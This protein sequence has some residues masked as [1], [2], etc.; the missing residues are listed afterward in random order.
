MATVLSFHLAAE[1]SALASEMPSPAQQPQ[2]SGTTT[3]TSTITCINFASPMVGNLA[4]E[5]AFGHLEAQGLLRC[6]RVTN[7]FDIFTQLPDRGNWLYV[8]A[9]CCG[10]TLITYLGWS[11]LFFLLFQNNVYRHVGMDLHMY[12]HTQWS[13]PCCCCGGGVG[14]GDAKSKSTRDQ[15]PKLY[16]YKIKHSRGTPHSFA[17]R[18]ASDW[19]KHWK[20]GIQRLLMIPFVMNFNTNHSLQEHLCRLS[21][22]A[23][24]LEGVYLQDLYAQKEKLA[25]PS[26]P[27]SVEVASSGMLM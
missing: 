7:H 5:H 25:R 4:F 27:L 19:K 3:A 10:A 17:W 13:W 24:E 16:S 9:C 14:V 2:A 26:S 21:G 12:K 15:K 20:Q 1:A 18:V 23:E 6:L 11:L 22:L 8:M